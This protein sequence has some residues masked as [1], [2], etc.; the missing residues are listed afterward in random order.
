MNRRRLLLVA[1]AMSLALVIPVAAFVL[2]GAAGLLVAVVVLQ[3]LLVAALLRVWMSLDAT[4]RQTQRET[5]EGLDRHLDEWARRADL[6]ALDT[7]VRQLTARMEAETSQV[8]SRLLEG[9]RRVW[10]LG[11]ETAR[12]IDHG[13][14]TQHEEVR[15]E[16]AGKLRAE[17][18]QIEALAALYHD[19][20]PD[21]AFPATRSWV[22]SPDLLRHLYE[23]VREHRPTV[24]LECGSGLSTAIMAYAIRDASYDGTIVALEHDEGYA[25]ATVRLLEAHGLADLVDVR[26]AP[27]QGVELD[28]EVWPWYDTDQLPEGPIGLVFVDGPPGDTRPLARYPA[29]IL[30]RDRLAAD[31]TIILDDVARDD[32]A[33]VVQRWSERLPDFTVVRHRHEKGTAEFRR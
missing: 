14:R 5:L 13:F 19:L 25:A 22:A 11:R 24:I 26:V 4:A 12:Q 23:T 2:S 1:G 17:F 20:R 9:E 18:A 15:R 27:L 6:S 10:E 32:E 7:A 16:L 21:R 33:E 31:A 30:L 3:V 29:A 8:E 28:G